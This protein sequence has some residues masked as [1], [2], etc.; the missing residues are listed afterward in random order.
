MSRIILVLAMMRDKDHRGFIEPFKGVVDEVVLTQADLKRSAAVDELLPILRHRWPRA[1]VNAKAAG[2]LDD[3]RQL[4]RPQD[5]I[6]VTG[7]LML[8]G[9]MKAALRG[10][11]L[12]RLRG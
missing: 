5:L 6:C 8:I 7:S 1:R 10:C 2:A 12:S 4:A 3:A 9:E 11:G